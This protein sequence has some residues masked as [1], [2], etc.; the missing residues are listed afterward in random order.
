MSVAAITAASTSLNTDT[1]YSEMMDVLCP[2]QREEET[3]LKHGYGLHNNVSTSRTLYIGCVYMLTD[4]T[5]I[6]VADSC[7][8]NLKAN[9]LSFREKG[10]FCWVISI[11]E[12]VDLYT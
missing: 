2:S 6:S 1:L 5:S 11:L 3:C 10:I 4:S 7:Y 12:L 9:V 8:E